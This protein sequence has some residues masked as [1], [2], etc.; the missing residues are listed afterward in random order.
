[1]LLFSVCS[2]CNPGEGWKAKYE[3]A[4]G[5][6]FQNVSKVETNNV[7]AVYTVSGHLSLANNGWKPHTKHSKVYSCHW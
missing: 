1:M 4:D 6:F 3:T 5:G 7:T 2:I